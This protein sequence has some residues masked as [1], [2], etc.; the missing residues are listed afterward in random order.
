MQ[1]IARSFSYKFTSDDLLKMKPCL[2]SLKE[3]GGMTNAW[4]FWNTATCWSGRHD[5][6]GRQ[7]RLFSK[8]SSGITL[9]LSFTSLQMGHSFFPQRTLSLAEHVRHTACSQEPTAQALASSQHRVHISFPVSLNWRE[10]SWETVDITIA[11]SF[12]SNK[13]NNFW[14]LTSCLPFN[15]IMDWIAWSNACFEYLFLIQW[16]NCHSIYN[17][18]N[19]CTTNRNSTLDT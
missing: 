19:N 18:T 14:F 2:R 3:E 8:F 10:N 13:W 12:N 16:R 5:Y 7:R 9:T 15:W 17:Y 4:G 11:S 6:N 1:R